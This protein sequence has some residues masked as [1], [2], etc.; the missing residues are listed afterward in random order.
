MVQR[1]KSC[2]CQSCHFFKTEKTPKREEGIQLFPVTIRW[3]SV[4]RVGFGGTA[5]GQICAASHRPHRAAWK[6]NQCW[7][8]MRCW[9]QYLRG[10]PSPLCPATAAA[11]RKMDVRSSPMPGK[12]GEQWKEGVLAGWSCEGLGFNQPVPV[13]T[14]GTRR[15]RCPPLNIKP[16]FIS[17][18][19][20]VQYWLS[21][22]NTT[23]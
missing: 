19:Q 11:S 20:S 16:V 23:K 1:D 17:W 3:H 15:I 21:I 7:S 12:R 4:L 9:Q 13:L 5:V 18:V 14:A 22:F 10:H 6:K 2:L 8:S